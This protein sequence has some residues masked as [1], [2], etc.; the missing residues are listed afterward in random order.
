LIHKQ[1]GA[2]VVS[3]EELLH[4]PVHVFAPCAVGG[5]L[6]R[7]VIENLNALIVCGAANNQLASVEDGDR[8]HERGIWY[9]PDFL[10]NAGGIIAVAREYLATGSESNVLNEVCRIPDR[11]EKLIAEVRGTDEPPTRVALRWAK[12]LL[13]KARQ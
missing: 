11:V 4:A 13:E 5:V 2:H 3:A 6:T 10:V 12:S 8:L 9:L 7:K 1:L